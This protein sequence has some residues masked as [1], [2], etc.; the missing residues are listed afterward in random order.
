MR[1]YKEFE[2]KTLDEAIAEACAYYDVPREKLEI[3][4]LQDAKTG[5][6]GLMG[7]RKAK[8]GARWAQVELSSKASRKETERTEPP[9]MPPDA[10]TDAPETSPLKTAQ[11]TEAHEGARSSRR[12]RS[13]RNRRSEAP[14]QCAGQEKTETGAAA[15]T[16]SDGSPEAPISSADPEPQPRPNETG[17]SG[18]GEAPLDATEDLPDGLPLASLESLDQKTLTRC[19]LETVERLTAPI[20]G[21]VSYT[22]DL[23]DNRVCVSIDCGEDFALLIGRDGQTLAALQYMS[24]RI[25]SRRMGTTVRVQLESD[26]YRER[27]NERLRETA[28][29][30]ARKLRETGKPQY[31]RPLSSFHRRI[32]HM[33][34]QDDPEITTRSKGDGPLKRVAIMKRK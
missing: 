22:V 21:E 16:R 31:T 5:I 8:I 18:A 26:N 27:Q 20:V 14:E 34:L 11:G 6:F 2:G 32:V 12:R 1:D 33:T 29:E 24:S 17:P 19:S 4:I 30:L 3:D 25:I 7:T 23:A 10:P 13:L 9:G 28:L 15:P